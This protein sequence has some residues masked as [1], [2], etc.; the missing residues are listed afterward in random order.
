V[1]SGP[2]TDKGGKTYYFVTMVKDGSEDA[3]LFLADEI[4]PDTP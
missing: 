3:T 4:E 2:Q 1:R